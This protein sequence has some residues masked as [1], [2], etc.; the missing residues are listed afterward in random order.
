MLADLL[1][2]CSYFIVGPVLGPQEGE[3][4]HCVG[5]S[6]PA[7]VCSP[8]DSARGAGIC[9]EVPVSGPV[10]GPAFLVSD[11]GPSWLGSLSV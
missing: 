5:L 4:V 7:R 8:G 9:H 3:R 2:L 1:F 10:L 11:E 6:Q